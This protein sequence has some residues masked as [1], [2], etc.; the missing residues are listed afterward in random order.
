VAAGKEG[1]GSAVPRLERPTTGYCP[2]EDLCVCESSDPQAT[3]AIPFAWLRRG[4]NAKPIE[5][6]TPTMRAVHDRRL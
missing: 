3:K 1:Q 6:Q 4:P 5:A 2:Q